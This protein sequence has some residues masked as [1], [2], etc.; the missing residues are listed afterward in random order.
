MSLKVRAVYRH[1]AFVPQEPCPLPEESE[2]DLIVQ[3]RIIPPE[4]SDPAER[5]RILKLVTESMQNNPIP[6]DAPRWTREQ[7]HE[8]R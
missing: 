2:V 7:L 3:G 5:A 6:A 1:G 4:I 8:R